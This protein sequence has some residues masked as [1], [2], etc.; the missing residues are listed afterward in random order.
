MKKPKFWGN[1]CGC[2]MFL[3]WVKFLWVKFLWVKFLWV[4]FLWVKFLWVS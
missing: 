4:K 2:P 3:P 1:F